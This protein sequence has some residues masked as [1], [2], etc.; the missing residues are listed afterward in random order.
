[1]LSLQRSLL[2]S[3]VVAHRLDRDC[4]FVCILFSVL[5]R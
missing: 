1:L 3:T 5:S 4:I 2:S